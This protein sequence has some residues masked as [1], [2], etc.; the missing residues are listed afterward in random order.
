MIK[1]IFLI[2]ILSVAFINANAQTSIEGNWDGNI[3][4]VGKQ[5]GIK[6]NFVNESGNY[7]GI[8]DIPSQGAK[9]MRLSNIV[10]GKS[11][12]ESVTFEL[13][14]PGAPATFD[15]HYYMDDSLSGKFV[16]AGFEGTFLL[17][18]ATVNPEEKKEVKPYKEEEVNF[19]NGN[20]SFAGTL[21]LPDMPGKH[22]AVVLITGSGAQDRDEEIFGF[23]IFEVIA[24]YLTK[25]G[26]AV[27][28][29]DDRNTGKSVGTPITESTSEDFAY[30]VIEA[31]KYLK[32]RNDIN[33]NMI[34][35]LGHSEGGMIAPMVAVKMNNELAFIVLMAGPSVKGEEI[36]KEQTRLINEANGKSNYKDSVQMQLFL[37]AVNGRIPMDTLA[38]ELKSD[39]GKEYD[40]MT[41]EQ[42]APIKNKESYIDERVKFVI[43]S[44]DNVWMK[45]FVNYDPRPTLEK[46]KVPVLALFGGKD[47]QVPRKQNEQPMRDALTK[48]GN[49][50]F[51]IRTFEDANHLFQSANTG[52][53]NEYGTL[54]KEFTPGFLEYITK[55]MLD[56]VTPTR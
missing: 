32:S 2:L 3:N 52:S 38:N 24:D 39:L 40:E 20:N 51:T 12:P 55:W 29:Y 31:V 9:G 54:K 26:I 10:I 47:L 16:Q 8:I 17:T 56:Y 28:R 21:S 27:L 7:S 25:N 5:I 15:G 50:H 49:T 4:V 36:V 45:Y 14:I 44:F 11:M 33:P 1:K 53:P 35:L 23:K 19:I 18:R 37:D 48:A 41:D 6:V 46:V 42:K 34:G 22:P 13:A 43:S 30:D